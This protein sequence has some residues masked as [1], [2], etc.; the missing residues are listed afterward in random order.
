MPVIMDDM[1]STPLMST[2][3]M[4]ATLAV[5]RARF[6]R[7]LLTAAAVGCA[8]ALVGIGYAFSAGEAHAL[9]ELNSE[10]SAVTPSSPHVIFFLVDDMGFNDIG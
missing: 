7:S 2:K 1:E 9:H 6:R 5:E 3:D 10:L 8:F 4:A